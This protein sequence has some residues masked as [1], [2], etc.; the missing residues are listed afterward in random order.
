VFN[1]KT[2]QNFL[3]KLENKNK[4]EILN[5]RTS[6]FLQ[7]NKKWNNNNNDIEGIQSLRMGV[8]VKEYMKLK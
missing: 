7:L 1:T 5:F 4:G 8:G 6:F 2:K 3:S